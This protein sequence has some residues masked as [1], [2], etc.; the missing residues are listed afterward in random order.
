MPFLHETLG[1]LRLYA[2]PSTFPSSLPNQACRS[3]ANNRASAHIQG[4]LSFLLGPVW[5]VALMKCQANS[6]HFESCEFKDLRHAS[7]FEG[8]GLLFKWSNIQASL[9]LRP[10]DLQ[11]C[12]RGFF[13]VPHYIFTPC[14]CL[15]SY[16]RSPY[17][18]L[19][20]KRSIR[21]QL[22]MDL[23]TCFSITILP[24]H[25]KDQSVQWLCCFLTLPS[26]NLASMLVVILYSIG[27]P[28]YVI[29]SLAITL[30]PDS[31]SH[32]G[33]GPLRQSGI[34]MDFLRFRETPGIFSYVS[35][36]PSYF[37]LVFPQHVDGLMRLIHLNCYPFALQVI[38]LSHFI[39]TLVC[40]FFCNWRIPPQARSQFIL[41]SCPSIWKD[42]HNSSIFVA[43]FSELTILQSILKYED[44]LILAGCVSFSTNVQLIG[45]GSD[46]V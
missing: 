19:L 30:Y 9:C 32:L 38:S 4:F 7:H 12:D 28:K 41:G 13:V 1:F 6:V 44:L 21:W 18:C 27:H 17:P 20:S 33:I 31:S 25:D 46:N 24:S 3:S 22:G 23:R 8:F 37:C 40:F 39:L 15:H 16:C 42:C 29:T 5:S 10:G 11:P 35:M 2:S 34:T 14:N 45:M 36:T 43:I 26:R